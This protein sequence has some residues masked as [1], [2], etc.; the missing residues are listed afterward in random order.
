MKE[1]LRGLLN[2]SLCV[3]R[4]RV[5]SKLVSPATLEEQKKSKT[6]TTRF[7]PL[8]ETPSNDA[9]ADPASFSHL[10]PTE[11]FLLPFLIFAKNTDAFFQF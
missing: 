4:V 6:D 9:G 7:F 3:I 10:A 8:T 2:A 1:G 11:R 5:F